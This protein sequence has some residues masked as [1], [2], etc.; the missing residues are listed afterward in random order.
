M[1]NTRRVL[2]CALRL[3]TTIAVPVMVASDGDFAGPARAAA[4]AAPAA[5]PSSAPTADGI[6]ISA[7]ELARLPTDTSAWVE[8]KKAA[9]GDLGEPN[10]AGYN[11]NHDVATLAVALVYARTGDGAY[12]A[13]A[14]DAIMSAI[15]TEDTGLRKGKG[16]ER[17]ALA[18]TVARNLVSYVIA[19]DLIDLA[20]HDPDMDGTFRRW[21][22]EIRHVDYP[23]RSVIEN[24][25]IRANNHGRMAGASRLA[26]ALYLDEAEEVE[27]TATVLRGILGDRA[28]H[29]GFDFPKDR[30]WQ[31]E[32]DRPLAVNRRGASK[33]GFSIDGAMPE[34]MRRGC[35][36]RVPPCPTGYPWEALQGIVVEAV[37]LTRRGHDVW[38]WSDR[39]ILR[40]VEYLDFLRR[41]Y[42]DQVWWA[43]GDDRWVPWVVNHAYGTEFL[44]E[45]PGG[46]AGKNMGWTDWSHA[47]GDC[48][49]GSLQGCSADRHCGDVDGNGKISAADA[50]LVLKHAVGE[51]VECPPARCDVDRSG[52]VSVTDAFAILVA[53]VGGPIELSCPG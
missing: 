32:P 17:G 23:D 36:F 44:T 40:A 39:A 42:P 16:S 46:R 5:A 18:V 26:V 53:A 52:A 35:E 20:G 34:E 8:V 50:L 2:A 31:E 38:R 29:D 11:A 7:A 4:P 30:S 19:A 28:A 10:M 1:T 47:D 24:D 9:D 27:R 22:A 25:E 12:R 13:R 41:T 15:G 3:L 48:R 37:M 51:A 45:A 43:T 14:A 6:W 21:I 49:A 33:D